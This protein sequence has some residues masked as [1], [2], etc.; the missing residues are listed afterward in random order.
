MQAEMAHF[1][2]MMQ[3]GFKEALMAYDQGRSI[4]RMKF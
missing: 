4:V 2:T 1:S 3:T